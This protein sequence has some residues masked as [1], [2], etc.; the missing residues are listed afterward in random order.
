MQWTKLLTEVWNCGVWLNG[1]SSAWTYCPC[2]RVKLEFSKPSLSKL[3]ETRR[4]S[5][6]SQIAA[7]HG[8]IIMPTASVSMPIWDHFQPQSQTC[9]KSCWK[10]GD[11]ISNSRSGRVCL[12]QRK[13]V[14][15][16]LRERGRRTL[17]LAPWL[18]FSG[19][20]DWEKSLW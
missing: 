19:L 14:T 11:H 4:P 12:W 1:L 10:C 7:Y 6:D 18:Y 13:T 5:F 9:S 3:N 8:V 2:N 20:S 17:S 16:I 15:E